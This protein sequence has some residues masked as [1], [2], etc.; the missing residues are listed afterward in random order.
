MQRSEITKI[1]IRA[2]GEIYPNFWSPDMN[3][4]QLEAVDSMTHAIL[5][6][7]PTNK[8]ANAWRGDYLC[9]LGEFKEALPHLEQAYIRGQRDSDTCY[10]YAIALF[11]DEAYDCA[12]FLIDPLAESY[13][14]DVYLTFMQA[15]AHF[16]L[17]DDKKA[18]HY[19][20][21]CITHLDDLRHDNLGKI[22]EMLMHKYGVADLD[23]VST[24]PE[25]P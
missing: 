21:Q 2:M 19:F 15:Y 1:F 24:V 25:A 5:K 20:G 7:D 16:K 14:K 10:N 9:K 13:P 17:G 3:N 22:E 6:D 12:L 23:N 4:E 18:D 11:H 8:I